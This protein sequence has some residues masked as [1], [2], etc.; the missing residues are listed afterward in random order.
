MTE[1]KLDVLLK[2]IEALATEGAIGRAHDLAGTPQERSGDQAHHK[3][4]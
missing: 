2:P 1:E 4:L 3:I